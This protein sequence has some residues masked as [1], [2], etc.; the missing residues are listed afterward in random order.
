[1]LR[2]MNFCSV[3]FLKCITHAV[4]KDSRFTS[5]PG[6]KSKAPTEASPPVQYSMR[7]NVA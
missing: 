6:P 7:G 2:G 3:Q 1:M 5:A 4:L